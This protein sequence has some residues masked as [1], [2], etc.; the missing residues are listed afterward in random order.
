[1]SQANTMKQRGRRIAA[2][3]AGITMIVAV[4]C[5]ATL[6][7][8]YKYHK[9]VITP[10]GREVYFTTEHNPDAKTCVPAAY[11]DCDNKILGS[12][13]IDGRT[14]NKTHFPHKMS[15]TANGLVI[16]RSWHSANGFQQQ[17]LVYRGKAYHFRDPARRLRRA[18]C[19]NGDQEYYIIEST[20]PMTLC[21]FANI[22]SKNSYYAANL[23]MGT[24]GYGKV[25][26]HIRNWWTIFWRGKQTNWICAE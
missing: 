4:L 19:S 16:S 5:C 7:Y 15:L 14:Y 1:M 23:D 12:Y 21:E 13:R 10:I 26:G 20:Y 2:L 9:I 22:C 8:N 17:T 24:Y 6:L 18:L 25:N 11:T 3:L